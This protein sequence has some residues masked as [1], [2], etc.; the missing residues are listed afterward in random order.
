MLH[1]RRDPLLVLN[2]GLHNP[3]GIRTFN[4]ESYDGLSSVELHIDPHVCLPVNHQ[5]KDG[6]CLDAIVTQGMHAWPSSSC[7][8][9][10]NKCWSSWKMRR[11]W[12]GGIPSLSW[13]MALIFSVV[14]DGSTKKAVIVFVV[15]VFT[16]ISIPGGGQSSGCTVIPSAFEFITKTTPNNN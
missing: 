5:V 11:C 6:F 12:S 2:L 4:F 16:K 7:L 1:L 9:M 13:I 8:G 10:S 14:F 3:N 15:S